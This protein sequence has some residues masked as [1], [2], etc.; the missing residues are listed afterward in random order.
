[1]R[2]ANRTLVACCYV[3]ALIV[4]LSLLMPAAPRA[5]SPQTAPP[6]TD[7]VVFAAASLQTALDD[8]A[9]AMAR[10]TGVRMRAS[11]AASSALARQIESG[12]PAEVFISADLEWMDYLSSK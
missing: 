7:V 3:C 4:L 1:M 8:L 12:A 5:V 11:Y 9:P 10:A 6:P 2:R